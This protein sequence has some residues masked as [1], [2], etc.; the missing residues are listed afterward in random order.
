MDT[1]NVNSAEDV[2][3]V[4]RWA[5]ADEEALELVGGGTKRGLGHIATGDGAPHQLNLSALSG[6]ALYEPEELVVSARPGTTVIALEQALATEGQR[7]AFEPPDWGPLYGQPIG[8]STIGGIVG[9]NLSG[10]RRLI[11]GAVRDHVLGLSCVSGRGEEFK[12]G[13][14]VVKNVTGYDLCKVLT[15]SYGTLA[16]ITEVTLRVVP[17]PARTSTVMVSDLDDAQGIAVLAT[18]LSG[19]SEI[20]AAAHIPADV[21]NGC[22]QSLTAMR[23]EG[24]GPSVEERLNM[25]GTSHPLEGLKMTILD[26][27]ESGQFW[28]ETRNVVAFANNQNCTLWRLSVPPSQGPAV[29]ARISQKVNARWFYDWGGGLIWLEVPEDLSDG[30]AVLIRDAVAEFGGHATLVRGAEQI[31]ANCPIFQPQPSALSNL[32]NHIKKAFDPNGILNPNRMAR[33]G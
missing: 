28:R 7:L 29:T 20:S 23:L 8:A 33:D 25:L 3:E 2:A 16:A 32:S 18:A 26:D 24:P 15:G 14:R 9:C 4:I 17:A 19:K 30:G 21:E 1:I 22:E 11:A 6:I 5:A 27:E 10:P 12:C 31:K 13:G